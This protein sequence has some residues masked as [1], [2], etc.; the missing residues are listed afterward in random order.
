M[1]QVAEFTEWAAF[2]AAGSAKRQAVQAGLPAGVSPREWRP[3]RQMVV[4]ISLVG[5][6]IEQPAGLRRPPAAAELLAG[7][8]LARPHQ[9]VAGPETPG[10]SRAPAVGHWWIGTAAPCACW[11][12]DRSGSTG[13]STNGPNSSQLGPA[14]IP[15]R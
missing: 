13:L 2:F 15:A 3:G 12:A 7:A 8:L 1:T 11:M 14:G 5:E 9:A 6:S 10:R 4:F